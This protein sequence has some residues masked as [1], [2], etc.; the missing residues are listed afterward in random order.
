MKKIYY[1]IIAKLFEGII[2]YPRKL[3]LSNNDTATFKKAMTLFY[4]KLLSK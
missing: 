3:N 4:E 1:Y 2:K